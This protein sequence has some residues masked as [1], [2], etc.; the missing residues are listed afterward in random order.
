MNLTDFERTPVH[1]VFARVRDLA[2]ARGAR[3]AGSELIGLIPKA[4]LAGSEEWLPTVENFRA[5]AVL[6]NA[7]DQ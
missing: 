1:A 6:E 4:A 3:I 7:L 5:E 2:A